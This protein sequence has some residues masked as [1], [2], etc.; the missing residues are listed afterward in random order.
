RATET[1]TRRTKYLHV[2]NRATAA[3]PDSHLVTTV[4]NVTQSRSFIGTIPTALSLSQPWKISYSDK[5]GGRSLSS[6]EYLSVTL[7]ATGN[8]F[9]IDAAS[10]RQLCVRRSFDA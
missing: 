8:Y 9:D 1:T 6:V 4:T 3:T 2:N 10:G 7:D 5:S